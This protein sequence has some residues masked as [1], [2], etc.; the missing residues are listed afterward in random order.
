MRPIPSQTTDPESGNGS[1][2][3]DRGA[4]WSVAKNMLAGLKGW[5]AVPAAVIALYCFLGIFGPSLAPFEP[6]RGTTNNR[7]CPPLAIDA[8]AAT[9]NQLSQSTECRTANILG[10][11]NQGRDVFSRLLH[12]ARSSLLVVG[13]SVVIGTFAGAVVGCVINGWHR[14]TRLVAYLILI[15]T[16]VPL[17]IFSLSSG[18]QPLIVLYVIFGVDWATL[19]VFSS[20]SSV[21]TLAIVAIAYR[22]D[23]TCRSGWLA[24]ADV[25]TDF[26]N[27][28]FCRNCIARSWF[29]HRG[30][31]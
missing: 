14:R 9:S 6:N 19:T 28:S 31:F 11:D 3:P 17:G 18:F 2:K 20:A 29:W 10:T 16:I 24:D 8:L 23:E 22:Y 30:S 5:Q 1:V 7:L 26:S 21:I 25:D 27:H 12:G 13:P 15:L 4:W